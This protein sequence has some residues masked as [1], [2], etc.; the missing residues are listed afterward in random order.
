MSFIM[1]YSRKGYICD[2]NIH[3]HVY[4]QIYLIKQFN[5]NRRRNTLQTESIVYIINIITYYIRYLCLKHIISNGVYVSKI[6]R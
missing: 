3:V 2:K 5:H 1:L 4:D 6:S